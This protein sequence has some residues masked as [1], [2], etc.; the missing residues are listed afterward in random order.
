MTDIDFETSRRSNGHSSFLKDNSGSNRSKA[1]LLRRLFCLSSLVLI[2]F[3]GAL[4]VAGALCRSASTLPEWIGAALLTA[5][6]VV[7]I[8]VTGRTA[9]TTNNRRL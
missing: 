2:G 4:L 9:K 8:F 6:M 5:G 7:M 3:G 1:P